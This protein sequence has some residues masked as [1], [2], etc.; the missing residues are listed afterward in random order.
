[1]IQ[2]YQS[3]F[4]ALHGVELIFLVAFT[5]LFLLRFYYLLF[6]TARIVFQKKMNL[7]DGTAKPLSLII[8]VRNE[9][10]NLRNNLPALLSIE[11][12]EFE[13]VVV[14]DYSQDDSFLVLGMLKKQ[15]ANLKISTLYQETPYSSKLAQNIALK[16]A[17]NDWV[18]MLPISVKN[19]DPAWISAFE[20][21]ISEQKNVILGYSAVHP[22]KQFINRIFRI[23]S[24]SAFLKS[25][26]FILNGMSY[27][28]CVENLAFTKVEYFKLGGYGK[29][30]NEHYANLE[31]IINSFIRKKTTTILLTPD[32]SIRKSVTLHWHDYLELLRKNFRVEKHLSPPK[33]IALIF[34][35]STRL[36]FLPVAAATIAIL[37]G[38]WIM[39][40][41]LLTIKIIPHLFII[42]ITQNRLNEHKIFLS[43]LAYDLIAPYFKFFYRWY[44]NRSNRKNKWRKMA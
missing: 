1:M 43:S 41:I 10:E 17:T 14:D 5:I 22:S 9:E 7:S 27:V 29:K 6:F 3:I 8:S 37:P 44:F 24:F 33:R 38:L 23:E 19:P 20:N 2:T 35:E 32:A 28:Y 12:L 26:G 30:I 16:A 40:L 25:T 36:L 21:Q 18:L 4:A 13:V 11:G 42:K 15:F 34:E 39:F 31:L